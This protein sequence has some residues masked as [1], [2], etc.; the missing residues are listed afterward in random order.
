MVPSS[1]SS[2]WGARS[3][4]TT[5]ISAQVEIEAPPDRV[6]QILTDL[7]R[8]HEWNP[9]TPRVESSLMVGDPVTLQ[10]RMRRD[11][12]LIQVERMTACEDQRELSWGLQMVAPIVLATNRRQLL[13][14]LAGGRTRYTTANEFRG[15]L[16]PLVML[17]YR[18]DMQR[19]FSEAAKALK[20]RAELSQQG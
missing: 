9:F 11:R 19:G 16:V 6:W 1:D 20:L 2:I 3:P 10:V 13:E 4:V 7:E 5:V 12:E 15:A 14:P 17:L 18:R 8:Y